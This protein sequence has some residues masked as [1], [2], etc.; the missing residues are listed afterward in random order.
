MDE[1]LEI[2]ASAVL[3]K[4]IDM[5]GILEAGVELDDA[6][7]VELHEDLSLNKGHI[8]FSLSLKFFLFDDFESILF[9][10]EA[11]KLDFTI[12]TTPNSFD[13]LKV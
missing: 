7:M 1:L 9:S 10:M 6:W 2:P 13:Y 8:L 11:N 3:E 12:G 5:L 4:K